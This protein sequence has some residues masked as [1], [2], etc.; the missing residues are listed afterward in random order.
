M[1]ILN[2]VSICRSYI[3]QKVSLSGSLL[4]LLQYKKSLHLSGASEMTQMV[5]YIFFNVLADY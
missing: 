4:A 5:E 2:I 1:Y 3:L